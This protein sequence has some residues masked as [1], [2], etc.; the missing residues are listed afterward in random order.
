MECS[1]PVF[2]KSEEM[3]L[4]GPQDCGEARCPLPFDSMQFVE[5]T[6]TYNQDLCSHDE[7]ANDA[8]GSVLRRGLCALPVAM[9]PRTP[10]PPSETCPIKNPGDDQWPFPNYAWNV[11][12]QSGYISSQVCFLLD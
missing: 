10:L 9:V 1:A 6:F 5:G 8:N 2:F 7:V 4:A 12:G 3:W 11:E